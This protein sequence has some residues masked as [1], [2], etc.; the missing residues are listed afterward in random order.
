MSRIWCLVPVAL[1][2]LAGCVSYTPPAPSPLASSASDAQAKQFV[3][4]QGKANLYV[5]RPSELIL[6]GKPNPY[7]VTLDGTEVGG[8]MPGMYFCFA[9]E[10]GDHTLSAASQDGVDSVKV[11]ADAG[12]NYYYQLSTSTADKKSRLSLG[13]VIFESMGK[14]MVNNTKRGQA[15]IE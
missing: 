2:V 12:K 3:P 1:L 5:S 10:P 8:I 7:R 15:A 9:L 14:L 6:F 11:H 4:P 13:L